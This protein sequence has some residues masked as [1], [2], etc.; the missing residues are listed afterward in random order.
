MRVILFPD[1]QTRFDCCY[2]WLLVSFRVY[3]GVNYF[4]LTDK[5]K[6]DARSDG[7]RVVVFLFLFVF[8]FSLSSPVSSLLLLLRDDL[9]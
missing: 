9:R 1:I 8:L 4:Y 2:F 7:R 6:S 3:V 5:V